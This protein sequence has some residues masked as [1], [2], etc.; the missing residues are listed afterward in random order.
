MAAQRTR[1][2]PCLVMGPR[3]TLSSDSRCLGV[4][5]AHEQS[6]SGAWK[7]ETSPISAQNG[8]EHPAH[9][10]DLADGVVAGVAFELAMDAPVQHGDLSVVVGEEV[11]QGLEAQRVG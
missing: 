10:R 4:R 6:R 3:L 5:P 7:R 1:G 11:A 2:E 8:S 9:P